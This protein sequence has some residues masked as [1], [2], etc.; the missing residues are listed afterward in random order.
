VN[1]VALPA[2]LEAAAGGFVPAAA[3]GAIRPHG[4]FGIDRSD[5]KDF[6]TLCAPSSER[7][8]K[9]AVR[10]GAQRCCLCSRARVCTWVPVARA[11]I[12]T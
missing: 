11:V 8:A 7:H 6:T 9:P 10:T 12:F 2:G 3:A 5:L 1:A 4:S